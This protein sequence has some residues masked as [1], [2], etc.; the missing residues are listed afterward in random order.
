VLR[1]TGINFESD[2]VTAYPTLDATARNSY[3]GAAGLEYLFDLHRQIILEG[4]V[5]ERWRGNTAGKQYALGARYQHVLTRDLILRL[6]AMKG[7]LQGQPDIWGGRV[8]LRLK[9]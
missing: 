6:D 1:N 5:V 9:F 4:A 3:G 7:F 8:E 2:G